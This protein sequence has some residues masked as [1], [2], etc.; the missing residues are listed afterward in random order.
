VRRK[1]LIV[2]G[3]LVFAALSV[4]VARYL[5]TEG[6]ERSAVKTLLEAQARGDA[7][8]MLDAMAPSCRA[9][10]RCRAIV[11]ADAAKL[12][13]GGDPK[14]ISYTSKTAYALGDATGVTR[15]AW[16]VIDKGL[17]VVQCVTVHRGGSAVA[18]RTVTLLRISAPIGNEASC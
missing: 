17:P 10:A 4:V 1:L 7:G 2:L 8:A 3:V 9:D 12:A 18:G 6:R 14:I 11:A 15:V 16:T 5:T 13:R